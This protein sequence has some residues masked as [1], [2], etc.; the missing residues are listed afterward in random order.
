MLANPRTVP[1]IIV[2][3]CLAALGTAFASQYWGG[4]EPCVLCWYQ[5]YAYGATMALGVL[6]LLFASHAA[7]RRIFVGLSGVGFL[8]GAGIAFFH[9]GVEQRWWEGTAECH[10]PTLDPNA[11]AE[12][13]VNQLLN[14]P[15]AFCD[16]IPWS[17]FGLSIA[18]YNVI[19]SLA[20]AAFCFWALR[21]SVTRKSQA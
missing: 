5:R 14:Q 12:E 7:I 6:A 21:R 2:A 8:A 18:G 20:F 16:E 11:S 15:V 13:M 19:A 9:V 3:V 4:L 17:L 1:V 10:A